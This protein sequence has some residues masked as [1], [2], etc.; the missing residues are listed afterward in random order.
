[1]IGWH[2]VAGA[3]PDRQVTPPENKL[4]IKPMIKVDATAQNLLKVKRSTW[5]VRIAAF[6][7]L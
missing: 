3:I 5:M 1:M 6:Y 2:S 7:G 4:K